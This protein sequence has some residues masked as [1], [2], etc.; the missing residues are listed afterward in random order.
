[1]ASAGL[2]PSNLPA[3]LRR[4]EQ[5]DLLGQPVGL[6]SGERQSALVGR[7]TLP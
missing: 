7:L 1:M 6:R 5:L 3:V 4:A 2:L